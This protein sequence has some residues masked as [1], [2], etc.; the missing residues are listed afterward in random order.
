MLTELQLQSKLVEAIKEEGGFGFKLSNKFLAGPPDLYLSHPSTG[1]VFIEMKLNSRMQR[2]V[3]VTDLQ[4]HTISKMQKA[5]TRCGIVVVIATPSVVGE[6][7]LFFTAD[8]KNRNLNNDG[9][10]EMYKKRGERWPVLDMM[11]HCAT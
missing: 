2:P 4:L 9:W 3:N 6:Y 1:T 7:D 10:V 5:G 11:R 8:P